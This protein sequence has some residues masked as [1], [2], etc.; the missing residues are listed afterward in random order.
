M[1][2]YRIYVDDTL[3]SSVTAE[4]LEAVI[5]CIRDEGEYRIKLRTFGEK[6]ESDDSNVVIAR[7]RRQQTGVSHSESMASDPATAALARTQSDR[8]ADQ[9]TDAS[10][11]LRHAQSQDHLSQVPI[12]MSKQ[13]ERND[14]H[15]V[16]SSTEYPLSTQQRAVF[17]ITPDRKTV[18]AASLAD[19][20]LEFHL[21]LDVFSGTSSVQPSNFGQSNR[22][23]DKFHSSQASQVT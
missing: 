1:L 7:F 20:C 22:H 14:A 5:D 19:G 8:M 10:A 16:T 3:K 17:P 2:G 11:Q 15:Q 13:R 23:G 6:G 4:K 18:F 9:R 21:L 12:I